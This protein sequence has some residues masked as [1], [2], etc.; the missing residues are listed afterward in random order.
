M[1]LTTAATLPGFNGQIDCETTT[2]GVNGALDCLKKDDIIIPLNTR[3]GTPLATHNPV[4]TNL[5]RVKK[6]GREPATW[7]GA[8]ERDRHQILLDYSLNFNFQYKAA[9]S[10]PVDSSANI[11]KFYPPAAANQYHYAGECSNRGICNT[12]TGLCQC[13]PGYSEDNCGVVNAISN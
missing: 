11:Y 13:F 9:Q 7:A 10:D 6:I 3:A 8:T 5:Y 2:V 12:K 4:Y 1:H